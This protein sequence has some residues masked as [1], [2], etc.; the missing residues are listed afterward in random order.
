MWTLLVTL[1]FLSV[2]LTGSFAILALLV[3][4]RDKATGK[5]T[6]WG[7]ISLTGIIVS[8]SIGLISQALEQ[9]KAKEAAD[10][11]VEQTRAELQRHSRL[12]AEITRTLQPIRTVKFTY[13]I[14]IDVDAPEFVA[15]RARL[16]SGVENYLRLF[17]SSDARPSFPSAEV[18]LSPSVSESTTGRVLS[19]RTNPGS[20][21]LPDELSEG[22]AYSALNFRPHVCFRKVP[23]DDPQCDYW[24][25]DG[26]LRFLVESEDVRFGHSLHISTQT[27]QIEVNDSN[28]AQ[29]QRFTRSN[30]KILAVPDLL[31]AQIV[32][33]LESISPMVPK[34][35]EPGVRSSQDTGIGTKTI[36]IPKQTLVLSLEGHEYWLRAPMLQSRVVEGHIYL[37]AT[38][39]STDA[40]L[41][42]LE[43]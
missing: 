18:G 3:D 20:K 10:A 22:L 8:T 13:W 30:G 6:K 9:I 37:F 11:A 35:G 19:F 16:V 2:S 4:Y 32:V 12:L 27:H 26:D 15:Y 17:P 28:L 34:P 31:G 41:A 39:P 42:K 7:K 21:Y 24:R 29:E 43:N 33:F 5:I 1:K 36:K 23:V 25:D 38:L 40:E 14:G